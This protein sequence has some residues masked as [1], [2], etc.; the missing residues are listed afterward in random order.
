[1]NNG[2]RHSVEVLIGFLLAAISCIAMAEADSITADAN[3]DY[4]ITYTS[5]SGDTQR[6]IWVPSTKIDPVVKWD[7]KVDPH[8][9][10]VLVYRYRFKNGPT[11]RQFLEGA[12][13][14]VSSVVADTQTTPSGW[15]GIMAPD[16]GKSFGTIV[17]WSF[18]GDDV[19]GIKPGAAQ[20]G[21]SVSSADLPG[22]GSVKLRGSAPAGQGFPDEGPTEASPIR[23]QLVDLQHNN[24][25]T[26]YAAMPKI[27]TG[28]PFDAVRTLSG[29]RA[30]L[31]QDLVSM[32]L[33]DP[34][35]AVQLDRSLQA[36]IDAAKLNNTDVLRKHLQDLLE[37]FKKEHHDI[38][39]GDHGED[40]DH[41]KPR[42]PG[43][44][45]KLAARVLDLD[46]RY[47]LNRSRLP[48]RD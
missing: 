39:E 46:L 8:K 43:S 42:K 44:I 21:F 27:S 29:I 7:V 26:R 16:A 35:F 12:R 22:V 24:F 10:E 2:Q 28:D 9:P 1:M 33:V 25:V 30:H 38:D 37:L 17:A 40:D 18:W 41:A 34:V 3:G 5:Y 45:D 31:N 48:N 15:R 32:K 19:G 6:V 23:Q 47:V 13:L 20:T 4:V 36:A 14:I 11:S